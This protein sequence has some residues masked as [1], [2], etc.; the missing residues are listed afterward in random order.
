M[1]LPAGTVTFLFTDIEGSTR[2]LQHLGDRYAE[3]LAAYREILRASAAKFSGQE[4]DTTG[5]AAFFA[6]PR[7]TDAVA[8][9][10]DAQHAGFEA[11]GYHGLHERLAG[12]IILTGYGRA[13]LP[14]KLG[15]GRHISAQMRR[16]VDI[17]DAPFYGRIGIDHAG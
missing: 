13:S 8:A 12:F 10:V 5:D 3:I 16:A 11:G 6:F 15:E 7:V 2:L 9:A 1:K 14:G 17:R 4:V